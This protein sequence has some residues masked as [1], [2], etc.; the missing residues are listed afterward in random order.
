LPFR[1][2]SLRCHES[3]LSGNHVIE[4]ACKKRKRRR[5]RVRKLLPKLGVAL[6]NLRRTLGWSLGELAAALGKPPN[7]RSDN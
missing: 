2:I 6:T 4:Q 7:L 1:E 3:R 5:F